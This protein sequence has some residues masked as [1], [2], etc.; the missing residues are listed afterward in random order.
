MMPLGMDVSSG[1]TT[2]PMP[3][4]HNQNLCGDMEPPGTSAPTGSCGLQTNITFTIIDLGDAHEVLG[5]VSSPRLVA[6]SHP[7]PGV[8]TI[9]AGHCPVDITPC[10]IA[11][12]PSLP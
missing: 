9:P 12:R 6:Q 11:Q 3:L 1:H 2:L 10:H 4:P 5:G 7:S 8:C